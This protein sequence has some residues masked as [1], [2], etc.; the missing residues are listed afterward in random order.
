[1]M[2]G[3]DDAMSVSKE[4]A[5]ATSSYAETE[6][7]C[8]G[9]HFRKFSFFRC[10]RTAQGD[11]VKEDSLVQNNKICILLHENFPFSIGKW[12]M[13]RL[14]L[15]DKTEKGDAK[16]LHCLTEST[17]SDFSSETT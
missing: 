14:F 13:G 6:A 7:A 17:F 8:C 2:I 15:V 4:L 5:L 1:M 16:V 12:R 9:E 3:K 11:S 10:S